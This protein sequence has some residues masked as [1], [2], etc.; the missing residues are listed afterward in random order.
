MKV[1]GQEQENDDDREDQTEAEAA[2]DLFE[3]LDLA[4]D[5]DAKVLGR[6]AC[7]RDGVAIAAADAAAANRPLD[8]RSQ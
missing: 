3:R 6:R 5:I 2:E 4:A 7:R 8:G 1:R